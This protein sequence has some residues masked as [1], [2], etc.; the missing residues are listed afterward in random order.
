MSVLGFDYEQVKDEM[1]YKEYKDYEALI[2][3]M[4]EEAEAER[5]RKWF[6]F[7]SN[8]GLKT[9]IKRCYI[10]GNVKERE[11]DFDNPVI[12]TIISYINTSTSTVSYDRRKKSDEELAE[13]GLTEEEIAFIHEERIRKSIS[14][15]R[16]NIYRRMNERKF[17]YAVTFTS[18]KNYINKNPKLLLKLAKNYLKDCDIQGVLVLEFFQ[19]ESK[20]WHIHGVV[21]KPVPFAGWVN[22]YGANEDSFDNKI[23]NF[24]K[25][26]AYYENK[27]LYCKPI[28]D[29]E[30]YYSYITKKIDL[31][32][33]KMKALYPNDAK[34]KLFD[35]V[36][37]STPNGSHIGNY[38]GFFEL[39][40]VFNSSIHNYNN[41]R[42][43]CV[44]RFN[45]AIEEGNFHFA[46]NSVDSW[47]YENLNLFLPLFNKFSCGLKRKN[48]WEFLDDDQKKLFK[49]L[50]N[51]LINIA[52]EYKKLQNLNDDN[53]GFKNEAYN[54]FCYITEKMA[55]E[56]REKFLKY[57]F[58]NIL[59][60]KE[61]IKICHIKEKPVFRHFI[62]EEFEEIVDWAYEE[63]EKRIEDEQIFESFLFVQKKL[64]EEKLLE[65]EL[66]IKE[67]LDKLQGIINYINILH[68]V[69]IRK[70]NKRFYSNIEN[71]IKKIYKAV[72][73]NYLLRFIGRLK[74]N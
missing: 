39:S 15:V 47:L 16:N 44:Y 6:D 23:E 12:E 35:A 24:N 69:A 59:E 38:I 34:I 37:T 7:V 46:N 40:N 25:D 53:Y 22:L 56:N 21:N 13:E 18:N 32:Y 64:E 50:K 43:E 33:R 11:Y 19:N 4:Y 62:Y 49:F 9:K 8:G 73:Y 61:E 71:I 27:N 1:S 26:C 2:I 17:Y 68:F 20:G 66:K 72:I 57:K 29:E 48:R 60:N 31:S 14:A 55:Y 45:K 65:K 74:I 28:I 51:D 70:E 67:I 63:A 54:V 5:K 52:E 3:N 42:K 41:I 30:R 36:G 10:N 58:N